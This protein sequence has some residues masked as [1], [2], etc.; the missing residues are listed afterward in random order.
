MQK[1]SVSEWFKFSRKGRNGTVIMLTAILLFTAIPF[2]FP[3]F[4]KQEKYDHTEFEKEIASLKIKPADSTGKYKRK[5][6]DS[7]DAYQPYN[8]PHDNKYK[9]KQEWKG[10]LFYFDPNTLDEAGWQKLG[11]M[12]KTIATIKNYLSKGGKF[13]KEEDIKKIWGINEELADKLIPYIRIEKKEYAA[14]EKPVYEKRTYTASIIDINTADTTA[15]IALPGIGS[16]LAQR[17]VTFRYKLGGFYKIEQVGET[18]GLADSTFQK[19]KH[20]LVLNSPSVKQININT[21]TV[22]EFKAHPYIRYVIGNAIV[23]YR[24]QHGNFSLVNDLKKIM[25]VTEDI[26][27]KALPYLKVE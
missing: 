7:D 26:F 9:S 2:L 15:F 27:T 8:Q 22:D 19:I 10:E 13:Y 25:L 12:D 21:A 16:K 3:F 1:Q 24:T 11:V 17:I 23:Q 18:F 4:I 14:T 5:F 20:R 6:D